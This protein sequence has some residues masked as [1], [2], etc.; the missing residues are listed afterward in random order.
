MTHSVGQKNKFKHF[1]SGK[2]LIDRKNHKT[3]N[4]KEIEPNFKYFIYIFTLRHSFLLH[5]YKPIIPYLI[6]T[7]SQ[8]KFFYFKST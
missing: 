7:N 6:N 2:L 1:S 3:R 8:N 4:N 5:F